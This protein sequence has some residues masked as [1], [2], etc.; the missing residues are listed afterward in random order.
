MKQ[1]H[2]SNSPAGYDHAFS[3]E[4]FYKQQHGNN[5]GTD[6]FMS[7]NLRGSSSSLSFPPPSPEDKGRDRGPS[8][9]AMPEIPEEFPILKQ[10]TDVEL[11]AYMTDPV[12][13]QNLMKSLSIVDSMAD[14]RDDVRQSNA[15]QAAQ[16]LEMV[17]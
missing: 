13:F 6:T 1:Q 14:I 8:L 9:I 12:A 10:K 5:T 4:D 15:K 16:T 7:S 11:R 2:A 17:S 3:N